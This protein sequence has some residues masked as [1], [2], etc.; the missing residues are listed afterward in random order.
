MS[1]ITEEKILEIR[2]KADIV[3][4]IESYIPLM[5]QGKNYFGVCPFHQ[6]HSPS[7]SVSREKQLYKCF[8]CGAG[9]NVFNFVKDY[10]N[11]NFYEAVSIV[12]KKIGIDVNY[13]N[14]SKSQ[15]K[16]SE[17]LKIMKI[18]S[19]FFQNNL[20]TKEGNIVKKYLEERHLSEEVIKNIQIEL[21]TSKNSLKKLL[22]QKKYKNEELEKL[23]LIK[24]YEDN[25]YDVFQNRLIFPLENSLGE[26]VGFAGRVYNKNDSPKYLN[27]KETEIFKKGEILYNYYAASKKARL[28]KKIILV[29]GY[30]DA[31]RMV[32]SG[33]SSTVASMGTSL[34]KEQI[35]LLAKL[36]VPIFLMLD[37]DEAG[38]INTYNNGLLIEENKIDLKIV[39]LSGAKDPDEYILKF[40]VDAM[41]NVLE[42]PMSFLEF[43]LDYLKEKHNLSDTKGLINYVK[44]VIKSITSLD[45]L[46]KD[47]TIRKLAK[48]YNLSYDLLKQEISLEESPKEIKEITI[49]N[50]KEK[51]NRYSMCASVILYYMM[52]DSKY[53]NIYQNKLG[54]FEEKKYRQIANEVLYYFAKNKVITLADFLAYAEISP[55]KDDIYEVVNSIKNEELSENNLIEYINVTKKI[56]IENNLKELKKELKECNDVNQKLNIGIKITE[57]QREKNEL[58]KEV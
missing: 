28:E 14:F 50:K 12:G 16:N 42:H 27:S 24:K 6:D 35:K 20:K 13:T 52:N 10:E 32:D 11:V 29:E 23:G 57:L 41:K 21:E 55:I 36:H 39:R 48:E 25:Y 33:F 2:Q 58:K 5:P 38:K 34:T 19:S 49:T 26:I 47:T 43:K 18:A 4:I 17:E 56:G 37:N 40:G 30:M 54:F 1:N 46:T 31:I 22:E 45:N 53:I 15:N 7:M 9:G 44:D 3:E 51:K 8:S